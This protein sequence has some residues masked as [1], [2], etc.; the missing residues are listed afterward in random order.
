GESKQ[1]A[2]TPGFDDDT[3]PTPENLAI[4]PTPKPEHSLG[5]KIVGAG[6]AVLTMGT[7][8]VGVIAGSAAGAGKIVKDVVTGNFVPGEP[9][10]EKLA[11]EIA[12]ELTYSP[13]TEAGRDA[14]K[15]VA[16]VMEE[17]KIPPFVPGLG[18]AGVAGRVGMGATRAGNAG[19]GT[20][21]RSSNALKGVEPASQELIDAVAKKR[22]ITWATEGSDAKRFLDLRGAEAAAFGT[23]D[24]ILRHNPSKAAVLEEFLHGSQQKLGIV[25]RL[26]TSGAGSAETHVKDFM[27]RH[28][29]ILG[30][31]QEDATILQ[32]LK[33]MGL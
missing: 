2:V 24:I 16:S 22:F 18:T 7:G 23:E 29:N 12:E 32:T 15:G 25:D 33:D 8:L 20:V 21:L 14:L 6:E 28:Q 26:G 31:S 11:T 27:I 30:I 10:A 3:I 19:K 9:E 5:E 13:R 17:A 1:V 4:K